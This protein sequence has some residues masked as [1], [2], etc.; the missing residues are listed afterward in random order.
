MTAFP[1]SSLWV[2]FSY[3]CLYFYPA[4]SVLC[5]TYATA[6]LL[7]KCYSCDGADLIEQWSGETVL[8]GSL[9]GYFLSLYTFV[10]SVLLHR[11]LE[12]VPT[13]VT[14]AISIIVL[15]F[16]HR[17][18]FEQIFGFYGQCVQAAES[19]AENFGRHLMR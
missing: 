6:I 16:I 2:I 8:E 9:F 19:F 1:H 4:V 3:A 13:Y 10:I 14:F 12:V 5:A 15:T 7:V 18:D 11:F 17:D